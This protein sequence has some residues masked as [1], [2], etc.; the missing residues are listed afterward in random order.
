MM[1]P[2]R[3]QEIIETKLTDC[4]ALI[5]NDMGDGEHFAAEIVSSEFDGLNLIRQHQLV[6]RALGDH[7]KSDI[8]ALSLK[9]FTPAQWAQ[10]A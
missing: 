10:R 4:T 8:H 1:D 6:Y 7:M 3:I 2:V 9:T 5:H